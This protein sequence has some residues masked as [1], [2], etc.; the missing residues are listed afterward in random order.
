MYHWYLSI[1]SL[2]HIQ[3][4]MN[5]H[6]HPPTHL[7]PSIHPH[8][9]L[10]L[11][12]LA[13][14][15]HEISSSLKGDLLIKW[16]KKENTT[17]SNKRNGMN[18]I[19]QNNNSHN[20]NNN[21][22]HNT[23][24]RVASMFASPDSRD[25]QGSPLTIATRHMEHGVAGGGAGGSAGGSGGSASGGR[26]PTT[27]THTNTIINTPTSPPLNSINPL[28]RFRHRLGGRRNKPRPPPSTYAFGCAL[29]DP[30]RFLYVFCS[31]DIFIGNQTHYVHYVSPKRD[32]VILHV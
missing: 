27:I 29:P 2:I 11:Y 15:T 32:S 25:D 7:T 20:N 6:F 16:G 30:L 8:P 9:F 3:P 19:S 24:N 26:D 23:S 12:T 22:S 14:S 17:P 21:N 10:Q 31:V 5:P 28:T 13:P 18:N 1:H 4:S